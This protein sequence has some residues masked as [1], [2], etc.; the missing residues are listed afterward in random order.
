M[1]KVAVVYPYDTGKSA[2]SGGV[3]KVAVSNLIAIQENGYQGYLL[4]PHGNSGL[5]TYVKEAFPDIEVIPVDF[6]ILK[7]YVDTKG[8]LKYLNVTKTIYNFFLRKKNLKKK[9]PK[10]QNLQLVMHAQALTQE[11]LILQIW[12]NFL[13]ALIMEQKLI[14]NF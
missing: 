8:I 11:Q 5:I 4:L 1:K 2:F 9:L 7:L 13:H 6:E 14:F 10:L 3:S 12:R